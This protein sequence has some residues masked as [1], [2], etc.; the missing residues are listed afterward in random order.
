M[1]NRFLK[2]IVMLS[3]ESRLIKYINIFL[4]TEHAHVSFLNYERCNAI[5]D[6]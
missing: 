1:F 3:Y 6:I 2:T 5:S 4:N